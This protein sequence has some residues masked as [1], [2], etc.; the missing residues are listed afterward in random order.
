MVHCHGRG[1]EFRVSSSP[2]FFSANDYGGFATRP[3]RVTPLKNH[4]PNDLPTLK[5]SPTGRFRERE[6]PCP[7]EDSILRVVRVPE[8]TEALLAGWNALKRLYFIGESAVLIWV[9]SLR[10]VQIFFFFVEYLAW[11][12]SWIVKQFRHAGPE[13]TANLVSGEWRTEEVTLAS[14]QALG[15]Q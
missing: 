2:P 11:Q 5:F 13:Q 14:G 12:L 6:Q 9:L 1:R 8:V 7:S 10:P 15:L 4:L 3:N